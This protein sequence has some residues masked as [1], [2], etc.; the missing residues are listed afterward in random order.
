MAKLYEPDIRYKHVQQAL[1]NTSLVDILDKYESTLFLYLKGRINSDDSTLKFIRQAVDKYNNKLHKK[2]I[3]ALLISGVTLEEVASVTGLPRQ[4]VQLF[5]KL[6]FDTDIFDTR[7]DYLSYIESEINDPELIDYYSHAFRVGPNY[8]RWDIG[9]KDLD[10][11]EKFIVKDFIQSAYLSGK[12]AM[13]KQLD[14]NVIKHWTTITHQYIR[15]L[16]DMGTEVKNP[17]ESLIF[18]LK[19]DNDSTSVDD[20]DPDT[21]I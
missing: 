3:I 5:E 20:L 8:V 11:D 18:K 16:S 10:I 17:L 9:D 19:V 13:L 12:S 14:I 2:I 4:S 1:E 7:L 21:I 6:F 15:L